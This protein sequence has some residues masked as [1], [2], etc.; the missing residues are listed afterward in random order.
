MLTAFRPTI[1]VWVLRR[2]KQ[3]WQCDAYTYELVDLRGLSATMHLGLDLTGPLCP[4][5]NH[6][7]PVTLLKSQMAPKPKL[8]I[9]SGS[10]ERIPGTHVWVRP[11]PRTHK[12]CGPRFPL[13][14]RT[15]CTRDCQAALVGKNVSSGVMTRKKAS[16]SPGTHMSC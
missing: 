13:S 8:L 2:P 9:S 4:I 1:F 5:S 3:F 10:K 11:K 16:Y 14:P 12:E 15:S 6:G 7:S